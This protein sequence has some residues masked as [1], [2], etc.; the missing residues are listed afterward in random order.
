[1]LVLSRK[2]DEKIIIGDSITLM[3]IEIKNDKVRLGIEAPKD[4][5]V[6]REEVYDAIKEQNAQNNTNCET[7]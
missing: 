5:T 7:P 3:V 4:V 6:H 2:K 1:M